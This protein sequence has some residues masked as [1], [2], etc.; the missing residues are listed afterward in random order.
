MVEPLSL[1]FKVGV[2]CN[3]MI[4]VVSVA[5][6]AILCF[7][8]NGNAKYRFACYQAHRYLYIFVLLCK[9]SFFHL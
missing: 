9:H 2:C 1:N 7:N 3:F 8:L 5:V 4:N 6:Y